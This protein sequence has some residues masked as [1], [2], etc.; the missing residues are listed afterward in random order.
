LWWFRRRFWQFCVANV[1]LIFFSN[2]HLISNDI[3]NLPN[4]VQA[5]FSSFVM[6][7]FLLC[8]MTIGIALSI[9]NKEE[10]FKTNVKMAMMLGLNNSL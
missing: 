4:Y 7:S 2:L 5:G 3:S 9:R 1:A 8:L 10:C 6:I